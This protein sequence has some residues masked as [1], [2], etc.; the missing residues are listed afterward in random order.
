MFKEGDVVILKSGGEPM[1]V[2]SVSEE[3]IDCV[4]SNNNKIERNSFT[5]VTLKHYET[6]KSKIS[7][8]GPSE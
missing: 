1:T 7:F 5:P 4:W 8:S 3:L 2:E 6:A